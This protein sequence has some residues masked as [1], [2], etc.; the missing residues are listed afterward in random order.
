MWAAGV[1]EDDAVL[2]ANA[3]AWEAICKGGKA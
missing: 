1:V 3:A 2:A